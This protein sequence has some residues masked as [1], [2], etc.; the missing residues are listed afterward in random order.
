MPRRPGDGERR[1]ARSGIGTPSDV[2]MRPAIV[3]P[4]GHLM[5]FFR[6]SFGGVCR[7]AAAKLELEILLERG[8]FD[9]HPNPTGARSGAVHDGAAALS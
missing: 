9:L 3:S 4:D 2:T 1:D 7:S 5:S 6:I 8:A